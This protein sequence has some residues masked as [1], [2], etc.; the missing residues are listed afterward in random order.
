MKNIIIIVTLILLSACAKETD[1]TGT[2]IS[3]KNNLNTVTFKP[4]KTIEIFSA[5]SKETTSVSY[6]STG[7]EI[8]FN[9]GLGTW[10]FV[11]NEDGSLTLNAVEKFVKK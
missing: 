8:S 3:T 7:K 11:S 10:K 1:M 4:G 5:A 6:E 2:Y 9:P